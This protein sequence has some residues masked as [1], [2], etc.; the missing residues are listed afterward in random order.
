MAIREGDNGQIDFDDP[1]YLTE[2]EFAKFEQVMRTVYGWVE[3]AEGIDIGRKRL[4]DGKN[5]FARWTPDEQVQL[6]DPSRSIEDLQ[7]DLGRS[8]MAIDIKRGFLHAVLLPNLKTKGFDYATMP[9]EKL[10]AHIQEFLDE[11]K[12]DAK[13]RRAELRI[14]ARTSIPDADLRKKDVPSSSATW[15]EIQD[16]ASKLPKPPPESPERCFHAFKDMVA[17]RKPVA[18]KFTLAQARAALVQAAAPP[19][20]P[21]ARAAVRPILDEVRR[22]VY[23]RST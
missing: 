3:L 18:G 17:S 7:R 21:E 16:F 12:E 20:S 8:W 13:R 19:E 14:A 6:I 9:R 15:A 22:I 2:E 11:R 23:T 1:F 5:V 4:G 10:A